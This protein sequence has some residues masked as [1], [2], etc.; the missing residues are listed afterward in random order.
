MDLVMHMAKGA[1]LTMQPA[2]KVI[3]GLTPGVQE[4]LSKGESVILNGQAQ[5]DGV[6]WTRAG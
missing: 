4:T 2:A 3:Q 5:D 1:E 6:S